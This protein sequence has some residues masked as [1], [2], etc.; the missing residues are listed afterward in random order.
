MHNAARRI[1]HLSDLPPL[2][3][4][5]LS[6]DG[7]LIDTTLEIWRFRSSLDGGKTIALHWARQD[8]LNILSPRARHLLK[9]YFADRIAR[10]KARTIENDFRMFLRLQEWLHA[11]IQPSAEWASLTEGLVRAFLQHGV[12]RTADKG[13]D[14]SRL[15]TFYRWGVARQHVDFDPAFLEILRSITAIGNAKGHNVRFRDVIRGPFSPDELL[16]IGRAV[17][18]N[19][20]TSEDR[21]IVMLHLELGHN[22]NASARLRNSDLI[23]YETTSG[24]VW[25]LDVPRVKKRISRRETRRRPISNAL[26][27]LLKSLAEGDPDGPLLHWL[28]T[29]SPEAAINVAMRRFAQ[30]ADLISPRTQLRMRMNARRFRFSIAT[31]MAEEGASLFQIA[32]VLDHTDTQNV[33]VYIET[34]SSIADPVALATDDALAPLVRRF[35]GRVIDS[36]EHLPAAGHSN[37]RIPAAVPHLGIPHLDVGG[38]G[39]CG[40]D[41][42]TDGLCQLLPPLSCYLCPSFA[43]LRTGPHRQMQES[44]DEFL[45]SHEHHSDRR[46]LL[47]LDQVRTAIRQVIEGV[48]TSE[49]SAP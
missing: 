29:S 7:Q 26:G 17:R 2:P 45:R 22:P 16:L 5:V 8:E 48:Q 44:I 21:A 18:E 13:N 10:K 35:Q 32:E 19:L 12:E 43:A 47:Q 28:P 6:F 34:A 23:R 46:I 27:S 31:H 38:I 4:S 49:A 30:A 37:Q 36:D 25:Q 39:L 15:R 42:D 20:G 24:A 3:V 11:R 1:S 33:R 9:L 40:R 14:F 41:A